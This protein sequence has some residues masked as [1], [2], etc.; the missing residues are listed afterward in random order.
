MGAGTKKYAWTGRNDRRSHEPLWR[1]ECN[2]RGIP[3]VSELDCFVASLL[4]MTSPNHHCEERSEAMQRES[5]WHIPRQRCNTT[6][7]TAPGT[8]FFY[9]SLAAASRTNVRSA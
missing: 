2:P 9:F 7:C 8:S 4:A 1:G 5:W 3:R 6:C